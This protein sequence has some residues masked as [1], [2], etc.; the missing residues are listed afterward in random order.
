MKIAIATEN[1]KVAGHFGHCRS[2]TI[3]EVEDNKIVEQTEVESPEHQP[4]VLPRF[5]SEMGAD[6]VISGGMGPMAQDL[7]RKLNIEPV[8]GAS[9]E[10]KDVALKLINGELELG[11]SQCDHESGDHDHDHHHNH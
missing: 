1:G 3:F 6:Y 2:Y 10:V 7:F 4:G 9:G 5:L 8:I 11:E